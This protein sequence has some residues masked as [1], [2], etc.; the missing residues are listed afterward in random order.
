MSAVYFL[1]PG[2]RLPESVL[3]THLSRI[4][5]ETFQALT[6]GAQPIQQQTLVHDAVLEGAVH[7]VWLW[8]VIAKTGGMPQTAAFEWEADG[9]PSMAAE[10]WRLHAY[11]NINGQL[12]DIESSITEAERDAMHDQVHALVQ[13]FGFF[14]QQWVGRWYLTRKDDW[15]VAVR[16]WCA[17]KHRALTPNSYS[18]EQATSFI[19]LQEAFSTYLANHPVNVARRAASQPTIDGFWPDGGS[20]RYLLKPSTLRAVMADESYVHGWAQNAGLLNFRTTRVNKEWPEAP[21]GDLL[22]VI[23]DLYD[24]YRCQD[25]ERWL[26]A[27]PHVWE[28]IQNLAA[29]AQQ[30]RCQSIV[31]IASG[32]TDTHTCTADLKGKSGGFFAR[33]S[34][35]KSADLSAFLSESL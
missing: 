2:A 14:L 26:Q 23:D 19:Q 11:T 8:R 20:R 6:A 9:G 29:Q 27:W 18:G 17:Q 3:K 12:E 28:K 5:A 31:L 15:A 21:Q 10:T 34:K 16:P 35:P 30:R 7:V 1:I 13:P 4:N 33:F 22:C 32:S 24:A 25:W